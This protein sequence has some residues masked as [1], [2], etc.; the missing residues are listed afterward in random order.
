MRNMD[1]SVSGTAT[2]P[3]FEPLSDDARAITIARSR[4][5][6]AAS[7]SRCGRELTTWRVKFCSAR[8]QEIEHCIF[9]VPV[10]KRKYINANLVPT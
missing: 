2:K 3:V 5:D 7:Y 9:I 4:C 6:V 8:H 1:Y 10:P